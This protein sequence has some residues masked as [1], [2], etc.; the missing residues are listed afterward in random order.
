MSWYVCMKALEPTR[1]LTDFTLRLG[2][3]CRQYIDVCA[4]DIEGCHGWYWLRN[5]NPEYNKT[6][7]RGSALYYKHWGLLNPEPCKLSRSD[8]AANAGRGVY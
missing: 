5:R 3:E 6:A 1:L 7:E 2:S 4:V 8:Q